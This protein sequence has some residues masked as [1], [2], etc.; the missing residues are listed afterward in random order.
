MKVF[1]FR[2]FHVDAASKHDANCIQCNFGQAKII[3]VLFPLFSGI[4]RTY[5]HTLF[6]PFFHPSTPDCTFEA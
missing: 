1:L 2:E 3:L 4:K 6:I 5:T